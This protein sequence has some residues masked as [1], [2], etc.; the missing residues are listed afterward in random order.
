MRGAAD[1]LNI[2]DCPTLFHTSFQNATL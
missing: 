1:F 2:A